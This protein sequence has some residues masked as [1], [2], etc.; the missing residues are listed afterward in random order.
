VSARSTATVQE[1]HQVLVHLLCE[2]I[3]RALDRSAGATGDVRVTGPE[4]VV[5]HDA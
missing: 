2:A 3:E 5:G 1:A 4:R